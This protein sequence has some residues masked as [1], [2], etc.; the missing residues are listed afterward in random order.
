MCV[1]KCTYKYS[2]NTLHSLVE[3]QKQKKRK[4][5]WTQKSAY[6]ISHTHKHNERSIII[7]DEAKKNGTFCDK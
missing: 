3:T 4:E 2:W 1:V 6:R 5:K 7:K